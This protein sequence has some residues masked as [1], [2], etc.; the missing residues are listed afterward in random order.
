[1]NQFSGSGGGIVNCQYGARSYEKFNL[2]YNGDQG[3]F[4]IQS[5]QFPGVFLRMDGTGVN[6]FSGSGAGVVNCQYGARSY[7]Q[8]K[9]RS[10]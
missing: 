9:L 7:E 8:F 10:A 2:T 1:M 4:T 3:S 6:Q 5:V